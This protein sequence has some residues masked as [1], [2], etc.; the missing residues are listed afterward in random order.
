VLRRVQRTFEHRSASGHRKSV[1]GHGRD[2]QECRTS[3]QMARAEFGAGMGHL[4]LAATH[5]ADS[6][7]SQVRPR[8]NAV[9]TV[10]LVPLVAAVRAGTAEAGKVGRK[11]GA[12]APRTRGSKMDSKRTKL[13]AGLLVAGAAAGVTGALVARRRS[14]AGWEEYEA[15]GRATVHTGTGTG[16]AAG[17]TDRDQDW[18]VVGKQTA[19]DWA[20][21]TKDIA[22]GEGAQKAKA[23]PAKAKQQAEKVSDPLDLTA[24]QFADNTAPSSATK[25]S[26]GL[27]G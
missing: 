20:T 12:K 6:V 27:T 10:T 9:R 1:S 17:A 26:R 16:L 2:A 19:H 3:G 4:W 24:K 14:R 21:A 22:G 7:S 8:L 25:N 11:A 5:G 18:D 23:E 13:L 15:A